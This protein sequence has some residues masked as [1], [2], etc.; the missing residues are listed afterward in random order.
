LE[1]IDIKGDFPAWIDLSTCSDNRKGFGEGVKEDGQSGP[2]I[3]E[4]H[5][6]SLVKMGIAVALCIRFVK[7][8]CANSFTVPHLNIMVMF[9]RA[10]P[11]LRGAHN[12]PFGYT[13]GCHHSSMPSIWERNALSLFVVGLRT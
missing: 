5:Q 11:A 2:R 6:A 8:A 12:E 1:F 7:G 3:P 10:I 4:A 9:C 13:E